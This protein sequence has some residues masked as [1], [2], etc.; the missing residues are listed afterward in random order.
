VATFVEPA[1]PDVIRRI[2]NSGDRRLAWEFFVFFSRFEYALKRVESYLMPGVGNAEANWNRFASDH[3]EQFNPD[4]TPAL[5]A[6][7]RYY[8]EKPPRKQ[9]RSD[10]EMS[11]SDPL[12]Y[13]RNEPLLVWLLR[14]VRVVRNNLFHGGKFPLIPISDPSHDRELLANAI[15]I[16]AACLPL[17]QRVSDLFVEGIDE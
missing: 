1:L 6:A 14:V 15:T 17:H 9:L 8:F 3:N 11:W 10:G 16:L 2:A 12:T 5:A 4:A 13:Q 7:V